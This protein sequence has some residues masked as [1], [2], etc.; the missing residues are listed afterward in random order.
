M[1]K[2]TVAIVYPGGAYGTYLE[3]CL[4][5]LVNNDDIDEPF[6]KNGN[7]HAFEGNQLINMAGWRNYAAGREQHKFVRVHP[8]RFPEECISN[9]VCEIAKDAAHLI[10]LYPGPQDVLL[11]VNNH[12]YKIYNNWFDHLFSQDLGLDKIYLNW[13]IE[14][15]TPVD[16]IPAWIKREFL[17][18]YLMPAWFDQVEWARPLEHNCQ[19]LLE[20]TVHDLLFD[21]VDTLLKIEKVCNFKYQRSPLYL[22][23]SHAKNLKLQKYLD[24]D[25]ICNAVIDSVKNNT[26]LT[27]NN[28]SLPS[29]AWIQWSLR[30]IG[31]E[32]KCHGLDVFPTD[33]E[34]LR[35]LLYV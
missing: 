19:N 15:G 11:T 6:T 7:S 27:W 14:S 31:H 22:L 30:N 8:K 23:P 18:F 16:Q 4:T 13:P 32:I 24:H 26:N 5:T 28:L 34:S 35:D 3:W 2:D 29:E 25:R 10:Y 17:S 12:F 21:F 33:S 9:S 1:S 20:I